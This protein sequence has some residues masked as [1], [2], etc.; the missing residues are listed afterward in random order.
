MIIMTQIKK[1]IVTWLRQWFYTKDEI[2]NNCE[3]MIVTYADGTTETYK[4]LKQ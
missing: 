1:D 4:V 3:N 2:N